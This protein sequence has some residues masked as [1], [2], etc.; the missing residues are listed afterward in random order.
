MTNTTLYFICLWDST[1]RAWL[2]IK[3]YPGTE[4]GSVQWRGQPITVKIIA[5][6][7]VDIKKSKETYPPDLYALLKSN[8]QKQVRRCKIRAV[9][10]AAR[11]WELGQF[12][13]LRRLVVIAAEDAEVSTETSLVCWLMAAKT[14][15]LILTD[16]HRS[17]VLGYVRALV[18][19]PVCRKL[20]VEDMYNPE[21]GPTEVLDSF[22]A[23][24][25]QIAGILLRT[26]YGGLSGDP[27]MISRCLDWL[28][29]SDTHL[30]SLGVKEWHEPLPKLLINPAAIDHHIYPSLIEKLEDLHPGYSQEFLRT[31][32]W[33]CSSRYNRRKICSNKKVWQDC[34][35]TIQP[36][37]RE[38]TREYLSRILKKFGGL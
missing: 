26:A 3:P 38:L 1:P 11:L 16:S 10:T 22:H 12:E 15:G 20:E 27:P 25:E 6:S 34:W 28:I 21:L 4:L 30:R 7:P 31:V 19:Y 37:F 33:K 35:K 9:A 17:W 18:Q 5:G 36:D 14:K 13:L 24:S 23:D 32:I 2:S 8:L 29:Q